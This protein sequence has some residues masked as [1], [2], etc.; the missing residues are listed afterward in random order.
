M[1]EDHVVIV[2]IVAFW[3]PTL[4]DQPRYVLMFPQKWED[5]PD[6][7]FNKSGLYGGFLSHR[8]TL[9]SSSISNDGIFHDINQRAWVPP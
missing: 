2:A 9:R 8:G 6:K 1:V 5:Y 3:A 7:P 4:S